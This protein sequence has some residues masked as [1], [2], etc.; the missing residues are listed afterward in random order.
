MTSLELQEWNAWRSRRLISVT[1][2][3]GNLALIETR[4]LDEGEE[5]SDEEALIGQPETVTATHEERREYDGK[6]IAKGIRLWDANSEGIQSF[7]TIDVYPFDPKWIFEA[8]FTP[9][10]EVRPVPFEYVRET[11]GLRNLAVPGEINVTIAG[12]EYALDAFDDDG[13]L[14]L[15]FGDPTNRTETYPA[16]RFLFVHRDDNSERVIINFNRA[17]VPPC[18]FSIHYN[19]PLPPPQNRIQVPILAGEKNPIFRNNYEIH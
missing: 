5:I 16:G 14:L 4:W 6:V 18:G 2:P 8:T 13:T 17:Y 12:V 9:H 7:E 15:A 11:P 1:S 19:C 10:G 3:Q